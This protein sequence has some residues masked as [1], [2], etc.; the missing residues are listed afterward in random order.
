VAVLQGEAALAREQVGRMARQLAGDM[1]SSTLG[2]PLSVE[3]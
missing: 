3:A 1:A 2:R